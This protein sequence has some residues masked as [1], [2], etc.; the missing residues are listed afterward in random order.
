MAQK[1]LIVDDDEPTRLGLAALLA[2]VGYETITASSVPTAK[3]VLATEQPDLLIVDIRLGDYNGLQ[4]I[5]VGPEPIPAIVMTGFAD[6][7]LEADARR[8]GADYLLKPVSPSTLYSAVARTLSKVV[9]TD[10]FVPRRWDRKDVVGHVPVR[11]EDTS[12]R[13][14][15]V[16]Y[17]G[18]RLEV[19]NSIGSVLPRAFMLIFPANGVSVPVDVVWERR[20]DE[21]TWLCGAAVGAPAEPQWRSL[22]DAL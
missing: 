3:R 13:L 9:R 11:I 17:G 4:L 12:A 10:G 16:G 6:P 7:V 5:V 1:I 2:H 21:T 22:V 14:L 15:D 18:V 8:L 19:P 20:A